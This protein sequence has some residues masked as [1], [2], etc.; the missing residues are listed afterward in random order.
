[1]EGGCNEKINGGSY[2]KSL[3]KNDRPV[4]EISNLDFKQ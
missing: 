2:I 1:M 3:A 4:N